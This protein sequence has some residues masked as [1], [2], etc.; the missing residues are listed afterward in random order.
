[1]ARHSAG[2]HSHLGSHRVLLP[3]HPNCSQ[4][5]GAFHFISGIE[6]ESKQ[7]NQPL[8]MN[9]LPKPSDLI[10]PERIQASVRSRFNPIA[11]L[12]PKLLASYL[13]A[14]RL[15]FFR[16]TALVWDAMERRDA[17]LQTVAP[18]RKK[19]VARHGWEILT[20]DDS[21]AAQQQKLALEY[22]YNHL[23]ATNALEENETGGFSLLVRQM[24]DAVG[25]R[26]AVH[27]IIWQPSPATPMAANGQSLPAPLTATFRFCPL[28]WFEGTQGRLRFLPT[29]FAIYGTDM[30]PG[31]WMVTVGD[32]VMEACSVAYIYK[33]LPLRDWLSYSEKFGTPGIIGHTTAAK[34]SVA[35][36]EFA[37]ALESFS[38]DWKVICNK[39]NSIDLVEP[40]GQGE[41]PFAPLVERMDRAMTALWRGADLGTLSSHNAAGASLQADES[42]ILEMDDAQMISETLTAQVSRYVLQYHFGDAPQL[43]YI[44]VRTV[45]KRDLSLDLQVDQFLLSAGVPISVKD[46]LERYGRPAPQPGEPLLKPTAAP[47]NEIKN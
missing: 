44:K 5:G 32:G 34:D 18:K 23:T 36:N 27:E 39:E 14:F 45:E 16:N 42:D 43:A 46:A 47:L 24:M 10:T 12:G 15:G 20:L 7:P 19:A 1:M 30:E 25:K 13:D 41:G 17:T 6:P 28:W 37:N 9:P 29:E 26:Y 40:K 2:P 3:D 11:G 21:P 38:Q 35:W 8:Y 4:R 22:F 33:T 31:G